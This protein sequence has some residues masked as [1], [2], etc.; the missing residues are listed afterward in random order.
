[1][2]IGDRWQRAQVVK[3][4]FAQENT[5]YNYDHRYLNDIFGHLLR[6]ENLPLSDY[7]LY[8]ITARL[9]SRFLPRQQAVVAL[10]GSLSYTS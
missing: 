2:E 9:S 1:M 8:T 10:S 3:P 4:F 6:N 7:L 5:Q